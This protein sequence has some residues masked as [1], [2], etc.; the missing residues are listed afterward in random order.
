M[1]LGNESV[2]G[3]GGSVS[4]LDHIFLDVD[5]VSEYCGVYG[6]QSTSCQSSAVALVLLYLHVQKGTTAAGDKECITDTL[7]HGFK[8]CQ[9]NQA[10]TINHLLERYKLGQRIPQTGREFMELAIGNYK[11]ECA[12]KVATVFPGAH[13]FAGARTVLDVYY[14]VGF[15]EGF[16]EKHINN[17]VI[18]TCISEYKKL[19]TVERLISFLVYRVREYVRCILSHIQKMHSSSYL[20]ALQ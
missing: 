2:Y 10:P 18:E 3:S 15:L 17:S 11:R 9:S 6:M 12:E 13:S 5:E 14:G 8:Y 20:H 4:R 16:S 7:R 19:F 1:E